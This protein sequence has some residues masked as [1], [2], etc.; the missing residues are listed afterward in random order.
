[1]HS[2]SIWNPDK[3]TV[4]CCF[5]A[6]FVIGPYFFEEITANGIQICY[7]TGQRYRD[8]LR[9]FVIPQLQHRGCLQGNISMQD[10]APS[11]IDRRAKQLLNS[12]SQ[13]HG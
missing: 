12:I 11:R 4:W 7:F 3:V 5:T 13:M 8:M 10:S 2:T 6:T 1:M 9:D